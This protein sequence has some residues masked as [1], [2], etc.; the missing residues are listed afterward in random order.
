MDHFKVIN[1]TY[2][3]LAGD[4][5]LQKIS[6]IVAQTVREGDLFARFGGEEFV[7]LMRDAH[8]KNALDLAERIRAKISNAEIIHDGQKIK[9]TVSCG[10]SEIEDNH[11]DY[12]DLI[13]MADQFLYRAKKQGRNRT[14]FSQ[15][16]L[17]A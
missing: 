16:N 13:A 1:D 11:K 2:G 12:L 15:D 10:L 5:V 7:I 6:A 9:V 3:H 8:I 4:L 17:S 14:C